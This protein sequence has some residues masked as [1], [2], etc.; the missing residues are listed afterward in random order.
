MKVELLA[1]HM[2]KKISIVT[3]TYNCAHNLERTIL[4]VIGQK[5]C[6]YE[7]VVIDGQSN[8]GTL[9]IIEKY[10]D[11]LSFFIS[12]PDNGIY[13]AMNKGLEHSNGDY[14]YF[15]NSGD[16][17][18][19]GVL[20]RIE[21]ILNECKADII[22]GDV[23]CCERERYII[24]KPIPLEAFGW[25]MPMCHQGVFLKKSSK[26]FDTKY[27]I[28]ADYNMLGE[29][30][31]EGKSFSYVPISI[32]YYDTNGV[33]SDYINRKKEFFDVSA[34]FYH[35]FNLTNTVMLKRMIYIFLDAINRERVIVGSE[36]EK[37][38]D[39]INEIVRYKDNVIVWGNGK[40]YRSLRRIIKLSELRISKIIDDNVSGINNYDD[41]IPVC[42][43]EVLNNE[44]DCSL[45]ILTEKYSDEIKD[46]IGRMRL[47]A[48]IQLIDFV[49]ANGKY[50]EKN[51]EYLL[52][53]AKEVNPAIKHFLG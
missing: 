6:S 46:I 51:R 29:M 36:D 32:A 50:I 20:E 13:D 47:D 49:S 44:S 41:G 7:Y 5:N 33:S 1:C 43:H 53:Y 18:V 12:E 2:E 30:Y 40:I 34:S 38:V 9:E 48:K 8:D 26:R 4:S 37:I 10:Q 17:L 27:K 25:T 35:R 39:Y 16:K 24:Q 31:F 14:I 45:L 15:L 21:W 42:T 52:A 28:A 23:I 22:F 11:S 19:E 3:V